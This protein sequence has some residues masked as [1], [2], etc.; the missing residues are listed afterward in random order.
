MAYE[1]PARAA[2]LTQS[3]TLGGTLSGD[4]STNF[5]NFVNFTINKKF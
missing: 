2:P 3:S 4:F 1:F 5:V